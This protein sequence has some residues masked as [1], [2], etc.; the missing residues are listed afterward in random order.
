MPVEG[1]GRVSTPEARATPEVIDEVSKARSTRY[2]IIGLWIAMAVMLAVFALAW[3]LERV[4]HCDNAYD[5]RADF[6]AID[7]GL[8]RQAHDEGLIDDDT[9]AD[10]ERFVRNGYDQLPE[11]A[12]CGD[13]L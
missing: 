4:R 6:E 8:W 7:V 13:L 10:A 3:R 1:G 11:P 2:V 12:A 9:F 5:T